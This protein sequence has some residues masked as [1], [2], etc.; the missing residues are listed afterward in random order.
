MF[1]VIFT[2]S[3]YF[4]HVR[5]T[6]NSDHQLRL[7]HLSFRPSVPSSACNNSTPAGRIFVK[8]YI[9]VF[10]QNVSMKFQSQWNMW[11]ITGTLHKDQCRFMIISHSILLRMRKFSDGFADDITTRILWSMTFFENRAAFEIMWKNIVELD[12]PQMTV[13]RILIEC[14]ITKTRYT[15]SRQVILLFSTPTIVA[16]MRLY[17]TL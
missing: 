16:Q 2:I 10:F 3:G 9:W 15:H 17:I 11:K 7:V 13:W 12:R 8:F 14:L 4:R 5:K 1:V 6:A